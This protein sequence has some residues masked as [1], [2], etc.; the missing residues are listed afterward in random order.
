MIYF[1]RH[2]E[3][4][5]NVKGL[6]AGQREDSPLTAKGRKQA[7]EAGGDIMSKQLAIQR[8]ISSPLKR[9]KETAEIIA[10]VIGIDP[11]AVSFD[12]RISEYD[13]GDFTGSPMRKISKQERS[14]PHG[15]EDPYS[16]QARVMEVI[17]WSEL[18]VGSTLIVSHAGVGRIIEAARIGI[19]A[20]DFYDVDPYPNGIVVELVLQ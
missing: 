6:F 2:G 11:L 9:A 8:I 20:Q 10:G 3:S 12:H 1:V 7:Y 18:Q 19:D 15:E 14:K 5:A 13:M 17:N 16:F 4:E